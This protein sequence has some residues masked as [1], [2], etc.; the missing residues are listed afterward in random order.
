VRFGC[1]IRDNQ[2]TY[3][4]HVDI[5][6]YLAP[7]GLSHRGGFVE[8]TLTTGEQLRMECAPLQKGVVSWIHGI[9]CVD[10]M[11]EVTLNGERGICDFETTNNALRG[12]HQPRMAVNA[13]IEDG[14]T[15]L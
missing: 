12:S 10:T 4:K 6:I 5:I 15:A 7:D 11:C 9:A 3:A 2:L 8:M 13:V 14:I 1:I